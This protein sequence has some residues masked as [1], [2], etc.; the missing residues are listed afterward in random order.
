MEIEGVRVVLRS[1]IDRDI[2]TIEKIMRCPGV[3]Q[4]WG[5]VDV[6]KELGD[7]DNHPLL[8]ECEGIAV[9]YIQYYEE[10]DPMYR[11]AQIDIGLHDDHQ[12]RGLGKD[13][14]RALARHLLSGGHHRVTIDPAAANERAIRCY[15]GV[16]FRPVGIM[17]DYERGP[18]GTWHDGLLMDLL[19][20]ELL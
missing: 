19:A 17:R 5:N 8:I 15:L 3:A 6:E 16:G 11:H 18:D 13:A 12:G 1:A 7:P 14:V 10:N 20:G 9:G 2:P 4:W